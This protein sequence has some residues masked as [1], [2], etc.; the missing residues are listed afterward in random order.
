M[1][2]IDQTY[3]CNVQNQILG[4]WKLQCCL[5]ICCSHPE[6]QT[7][8]ISNPRLES[9]QFASFL[10]DRLVEHI[11]KDFKLNPEI[12]M[13]IEHHTGSC[14]QSTAMVFTHITFQWT[15]QRVR[16]LQRKLIN[17]KQAQFLSGESLEFLISSCEVTP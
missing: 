1:K 7:I 17:Y 9:G 4:N 3:G 2:I 13:W 12:I 5:Y 16:N 11:I 8:I 6:Q 10:I 15:E 14:E